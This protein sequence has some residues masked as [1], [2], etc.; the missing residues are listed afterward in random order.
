MDI[1]SLIPK[2]QVVDVL[3]PVTDEPTGFK[4]TVAHQSDR[5]IIDR[6]ATEFKDF[7]GSETDRNRL[8]VVL[9]VVGWE[10][11][12]GAYFNEPGNKPKFSLDAL[13]EVCAVPPVE[14][15]IYH[16]VINRAGFYKG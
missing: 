4:L 15:A 7:D 3:H 14:D 10:W 12:G 6:Y 9:R 2:E 16:A 5:R 13:K 8:A 11:G 1:G